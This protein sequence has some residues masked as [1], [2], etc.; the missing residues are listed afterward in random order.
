VRIF[1]HIE[2]ASCRVCVYSVFIWPSVERGEAL[3]ARTRSR[4]VY[5]TVLI[6]FYRWVKRQIIVRIIRES[7]LAWR[8][9]MPQNSNEIGTHRV[10]YF[11]AGVKQ[12]SRLIW[13]YRHDFVGRCKWKSKTY[14]IY[15]LFLL[16]ILVCFIADTIRFSK[17]SSILDHEPPLCHFRG[18]A[19][20]WEPVDV[21]SPLEYCIEKYRI[22]SRKSGTLTRAWRPSIVS[23]FYVALKSGRVKTPFCRVSFKVTRNPIA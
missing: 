13:S 14:S 22:I 18:W 10:K 12:L 20:G 23:R 11:E 7:I 9:L 16:L 8:E 17:R 6:K 3:R 21:H 1:Y 5:V 4:R 15:L 2:I 19:T